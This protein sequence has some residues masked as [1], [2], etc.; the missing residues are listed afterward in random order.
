MLPREFGADDKNTS[1]K[2]N[3][4]DVPSQLLSQVI[5]SVGVCRDLTPDLILCER[6]KEKQR[7]RNSKQK[8]KDFHQLG[9][10]VR[11]GCSGSGEMLSE[12][13]KSQARVGVNR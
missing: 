4:P 2:R 7:V 1:S 8:C 12:D 3:K 9:S 11:H 5:K 6:Q 13:Q 10:E